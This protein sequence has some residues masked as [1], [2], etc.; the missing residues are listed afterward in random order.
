MPYQTRAE[1]AFKAE[2]EDQRWMTMVEAL[3]HIMSVDDC[4]TE[5][6]LREM[7]KAVEDR[8]LKVRWDV[9]KLHTYNPLAFCEDARVRLEKRGAHLLKA[10]E[11]ACKTDAPDLGPSLF[12]KDLDDIIAQATSNPDK[13]VE[14]F[15]DL[16]ID[17]KTVWVLREQ[18]VEHWPD[19]ELQSR[20]LSTP[21]KNQEQKRKRPIAYGIEQAINVLFRGRNPEGMMSRS[22]IFDGA[23]LGMID[24]Q[25]R[26]CR[27]GFSRHGQIY[28]D[29]QHRV[30]TGKWQEGRYA[31]A[32]RRPSSQ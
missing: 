28:R 32:H 22:A 15:G 1:R 7:L 2:R 21:P 24:G 25:L 14:G 4:D 19:V 9:G 6:A 20:P 17:Y 3:I 5:T 11:C 18:V 12:G 26:R 10:L 8:A 29:G 16:I 30:T 23:M 13:S 27:Y 31:H